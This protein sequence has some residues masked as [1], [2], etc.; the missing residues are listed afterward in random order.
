[1]AKPLDKA[2]GQ[3]GQP[4]QDSPG[5]E[6]DSLDLATAALQLG[7]TPE[8]LRKRLQRG[9]IRGFKTAD[10][11]WRVRL[12]KPT[13]QTGQ[14][15]Q[16]SPG[17]VVQDDAALV[18]AL[19]DEVAFLRSQLQARDEEVRRAHILLQ[20]SQQQVLQLTNQRP[21]EP[22]RQRSWLAKLFRR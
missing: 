22:E 20:Q 12:D 2:A 9:K 4:V 15:V 13:G 11:A 7:I 18:A 1:M 3:T 5:Q 6:Q 10:G 17:Q 19:R 8:T 14:P 16:D 21:A